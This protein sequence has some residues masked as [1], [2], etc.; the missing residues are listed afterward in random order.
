MVPSR[1]HLRSSTSR[2]PPPFLYCSLRFL[3]FSFAPNLKSPQIILQ[4]SNYGLR[5][6]LNVHDQSVTS[7]RQDGT[8]H[9][10]PTTLI[11][12]SI[13]TET[14]Q[15]LEFLTDNNVI[16]RDQFDAIVR[17]LPS[18]TSLTGASVVPTP[19]M[20]N[21]SL[22]NTNGTRNEKVAS[23]YD[24]TPQQSYNPPPAYGNPSPAP[25]PPA[26]AAPVL[27]TAV[28]L[29]AYNG[30]DA[31][32]LNLAPNDH[33]AITEYMN[34]EWWKGRNERTGQEGIF[35]RS[36][37]RLEENKALSPGPQQSSYGNMPMDVSQNAQ[38]QQQQQP[39][40]EKKKGTA[41]KIGGKLGNAALFGAGGKFIQHV[42]SYGSRY[43]D[44][45]DSYYR[46]QHRQ[47]YFLSIF[48]KVVHKLFCLFGRLWFDEALDSHMLFRSK[49][50]EAIAFCKAG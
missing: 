23:L 50:M 27:A 47:L 13:L 24:N 29:Y 22:S 32:D 5:R 6:V 4:P 7:N 28:S 45:M 40:G 18:E 49:I 39:E 8:F 38:Q 26:A 10:T 14:S 33:I 2:V 31:G 44:H 46:K 35:P 16:T 21:L 11:K 1:L 9:K 12:E 20:N 30:T 19:A 42:N 15:E 25:P 37:V 17:Q 48:C 41:S 43:T 34:A 3:S 36:Y